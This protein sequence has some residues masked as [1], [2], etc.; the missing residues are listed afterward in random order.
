MHHHRRSIRLRTFDYR[1]PGLYA[2][3]ICTEHRAQ[4]F[5]QIADGAM[6]LS[7]SG[8]MALHTWNEIPDAYPGVDIDAFVV[9]PNHIHGIVYL[10][11]ADQDV[12]PRTT[13]PIDTNTVG[14]PPRG[15]PLPPQNPPISETRAHEQSATNMV[16]N[17]GIGAGHPG[18]PRR[19][20][21]TESCDDVR[22][23]GERRLSLF[24]VVE[25]YK[26]LTTKRYGD[27]V[28]NDGWTSYP[29]KLWQRGYYERVVRDERE[30]DKFRR[31]IE[32]NPVRWFEDRYRE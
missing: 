16:S 1:T 9:M 21:P 28:R 5:G 23:A 30:L 19:G 4:L 25:R 10:M 2:V 29:G 32:A 15:R 31:Y 7:P 11:P 20:A 18:R 27:G 26:S 12:Y 17:P 14:A 6:M 3:T 8:E 22:P 13:L 24:D